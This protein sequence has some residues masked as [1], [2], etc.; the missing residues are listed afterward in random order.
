MKKIN[1]KLLVTAFA[2]QYFL[3]LN[4]TFAQNSLC[5]KPIKAGWETAKPFQFKEKINSQV[6]TLKFL[7]QF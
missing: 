3:F 6:V 7:E 4:P 1:Q 5:P 2:T